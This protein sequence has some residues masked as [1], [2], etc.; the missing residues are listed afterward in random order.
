MSDKP[1]KLLEAK[2]LFGD[3]KRTLKS[4]AELEMQIA[5][6][7]DTL[8]T[9]VTMYAYFRDQLVKQRAALAEVVGNDP[10]LPPPPT[11]IDPFGT[12]PLLF[13]AVA[14]TFIEAL[15]GDGLP[16]GTTLPDVLDR[17]VQLKAIQ[18]V[19]RVESRLD[20]A[21]LNMPEPEVVN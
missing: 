5:D 14:G 11:V 15:T 4:F 7:F 9:N 1:E 12:G 19:T 20:A 8:H 16:D 13:S 3:L 6:I 2:S 21:L 17:P 18:R 10:D